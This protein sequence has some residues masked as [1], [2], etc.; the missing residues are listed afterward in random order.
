MLGQGAC[1]RHTDSDEKLG[2]MLP[3]ETAG[4]ALRQ[5]GTRHRPRALSVKVLLSRRRGMT[6]TS[7]SWRLQRGVGMSETC[8]NKSNSRQRREASDSRCPRQM[9]RARAL[10]KWPSA[11]CTHV[12]GGA[13]PHTPA[14]LHS[15]GEGEQGHQVPS[16]W[17]SPLQTSWNKESAGRVARH[18]PG[19]GGTR[20]G[21]CACSQ[22]TS[23]RREMFVTL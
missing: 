2:T 14:L 18:C 9:A 19:A 13:R 21:S 17:P 22:G 23:I 5:S 12:I 10:Q 8:K 15:G 1:H 16:S 6:M 4:M 3:L 11:L 20:A 7:P